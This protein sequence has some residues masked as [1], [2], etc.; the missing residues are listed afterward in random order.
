MRSN[1]MRI[2]VCST[3][4][5]SARAA[6][7]LGGFSDT[8]LIDTDQNQALVQSLHS[9]SSYYKIAAVHFVVG[10]SGQGFASPAKENDFSDPT[11]EDCKRFGYTITS[12]ESGLFN[13]ACPYND[14]I[15]D[16]CCDAAY[17]YTASTCPAPKMLSADS[18]GGKYKCSCDPNAYPYASCD[19]PQ[20]KGETCSDETGTR[21]KTCSCP[22][23][24]STPYGCQEYYAAPCGSVC[25]TAY[26]DNCRNRTAVQTPYG[27][28]TYFSDCSSKCQK[29]YADN[30]RNR[31]A[32]SAPYGCLQYYGDCQSKCEI[33]YADNCHNRTAVT[34]P[35]GCQTYFSDCGSKCQ[36]AYSDNCHNQTAVISSCP[37]NATCSY[38]SDCSSKIQSWTCKNGYTKSGNSCIS[39][40]T[41]TP[42][43]ENGYTLENHWIYGDPAPGTRSAKCSSCGATVYINCYEPCTYYDGVVEG[44]YGNMTYSCCCPYSYYLNNT[45]SHGCCSYN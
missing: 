43:C 5:L 30:C 4:V 35:Y 25:K 22:T 11:S 38:F 31:N 39:S 23:S 2:S 12:C 21:Y 14:K 20:I 19:S 16:K 3:V 27:C 34:A 24:V 17:T 7:A 9:V 41:H 1:L 42:V 26:G 33:A 10:K 32:V 15:Y 40:H 45:F 13:Q 8:G 44:E 28:E 6:F 18:C 36:T 37:S 29:S